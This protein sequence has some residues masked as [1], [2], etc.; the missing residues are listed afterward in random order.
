MF[1][2][3]K[4]VFFSKIVFWVSQRWNW[5]S[6]LA[7]SSLDAPLERNALYGLHNER[8]F[9]LDLNYSFCSHLKLSTDIGYSLCLQG[10]FAE[11]RCISVKRSCS[12]PTHNVLLI[13]ECTQIKT[14]PLRFRTCI[15]LKITVYLVCFHWCPEACFSFHSP[16]KRL[17]MCLI[18][19]IYLG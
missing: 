18:A 1:S 6:W 11:F 5:W 13:L 4:L 17:D 16:H 7:I 10:K 8:V 15:I 9:V 19:H 14:D 12:R 3:W 2:E